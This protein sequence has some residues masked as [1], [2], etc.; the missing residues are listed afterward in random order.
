MQ[1]YT[2]VLT[3]TV[4]T[5][6]LFEA[7]DL[8]SPAGAKVAADD[9]PVL[10]VSKSPSTVVGDP[11]AVMLI[12]IVRVK[13]VGA[14]TLGQKVMSAATGG[15]KASGAT[16]ANPVGTALSAAADGEFVTIYFR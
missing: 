14:I 9:A 2:D 7:Y 12:G 6:G 5:T 1:F 16:P 15:V 8:V 4:I 3:T 11:A 13:A 10:G